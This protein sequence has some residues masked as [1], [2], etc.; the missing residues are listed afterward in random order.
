MVALILSDVIDDPLEFIASGPTF[1]S[2]N[3]YRVTLD[4]LK[5]YKLLDEMPHQ[6]LDHLLQQERSNTIE[7]NHRYLND[8]YFPRLIRTITHP[9]LISVK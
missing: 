6:F 2:G 5:K 4:L 8:N 3:K 1:Y 7:E 9:R